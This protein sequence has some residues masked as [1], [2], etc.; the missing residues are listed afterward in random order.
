MSARGEQAAFEAFYRG[1]HAR[2]LGLLTVAIGE[3]EPAADACSEAFV[4][5]WERWERVGQLEAPAGW[6]YRVGINVARRQARRR[7]LEQR[8]A[9][10]FLPASAVELPAAVDPALWAA[11][12]KLTFRQRSV[13]A[14]RHVIGLSQNETAAVLGV[15]PGTVSATLVAARH[16]LADELGPQPSSAQELRHA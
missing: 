13:V 2:L 7:A 10:R 3:V 14:L 12:Q 16:K 4:R 1:E 9:R 6:V 5:A 15:R 8:L 11:L